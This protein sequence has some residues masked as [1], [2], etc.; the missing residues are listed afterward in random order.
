MSQVLYFQK[1]NT[2][3]YKNDTLGELKE[4]KEYAARFYD[5]SGERTNLTLCLKT[6]QEGDTLCVASETSLADDAATAVEILGDLARR[7][8]DV[9]IDRTGRLIPAKVSPFK[10]LKRDLAE[11]LRAFQN[12]FISYRMREGRKNSTKKLGRP[13]NP[14]PKGFEEA[15]DAWISGRIKSTEAAAKCGMALSTFRKWAKCTK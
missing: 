13:A 9:W 5:N 6:L 15:R 1:S 14:L 7:G 11:T 3:S 8:I 12:A 4:P 10:N 2:P